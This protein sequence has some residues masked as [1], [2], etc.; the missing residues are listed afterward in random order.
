MTGL[1]PRQAEILRF[2]LGYHQRK[3]YIAW[4]DRAARSIRLL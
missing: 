2:I 1:S 4:D 3:G